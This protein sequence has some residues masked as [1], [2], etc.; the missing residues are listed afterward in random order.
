[1]FNLPSYLGGNIAGHGQQDVNTPI[2][3]PYLNVNPRYLNYEPEF[4]FPQGAKRQRGRLEMSFSQIGGSVMVGGAFGGAKG[5]ISGLNEVKGERGKVMRVTIVNHVAKMGASYAQSLGCVGLLYSS[6][7]TIISYGRDVEDYWN[8]L[9]SGVSTGLL[10]RSPGGLR[11]SL[12]GGAFGGAISL[13]M[14]AC[15]HFDD[16]RRRIF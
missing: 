12:I 2:M 14:V 7:G 10:F 9:L 4:I 11:S 15:T 3:S 8:T 16:I 13:M 1:M 5:L 6:L